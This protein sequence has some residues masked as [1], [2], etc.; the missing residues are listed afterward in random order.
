[1]GWL[2]LRLHNK[3]PKKEKELFKYDGLQCKVFFYGDFKENLNLRNPISPYTRTFNGNYDQNLR[4]S[5][6]NF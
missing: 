3:I 4:D 1:M 5:E 6:R 2:P